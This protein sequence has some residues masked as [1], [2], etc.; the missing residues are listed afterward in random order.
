MRCNAWWLR[1]PRRWDQRTWSTTRARQGDGG[2]RHDDRA[3]DI[4]YLQ[5]LLADERFDTT[6]VA[7]DALTKDGWTVE[8]FT[9]RV[10][11]QSRSK[12]R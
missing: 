4:G 6:V 5:Q 11:Q 9:F 3:G 7:N 12:I 2:R 1:S 10:T 8:Y